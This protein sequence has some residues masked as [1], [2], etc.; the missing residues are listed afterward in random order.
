MKTTLRKYISITL[1]HAEKR[2]VSTHEVIQRLRKIFMC[3]AIVVATEKHKDEEGYHFHIALKNKDA[4]KHTATKRIRDIFQE[5][6]GM[7]CKVQFQKGI[8]N[9]LAYIT[10]ED[11]TP[12]V[13]GE[14]SLE[15]IL[16]MAEGARNHKRNEIV[17]AG[18]IIQKIMQC[19]DWYNVY[20]DPILRERLLK[21]YNN[22][23]KIHEDYQIIKNIKSTVGERLVEYLGN[24]KWPTEYSPEQIKEKYVLIDWVACQLCFRRPIKTKQLF[25][26]GEPSTQKTLII[27]YLAK[28]LRVYFVSARR[29]D[30]AGADD[31]YD[32][33]V[34]DEFNEPEEGDF[35]VTAATEGGTAYA[36][37]L[38]RVLDGQECRLDAKY[39]K[40]FT[41]KINVPIIM[42]A[43]RL[44][45][46]VKKSGPMQER[47]IRLRFKTNI[48]QLDEERV[49]ATLWGCIRRRTVRN[50][51]MQRGETINVDIN[52][53]YNEARAKEMV[54]KKGREARKN[55]RRKLITREN[56][57]IK[58]KE[59]ALKYR[60]TRYAYEQWEEHQMLEATI[61]EKKIGG[62]IVSFINYAIIP[63]E[64]KGVTKDSEEE[65]ESFNDTRRGANF[66]IRR[67]KSETESDYMTWPIRA[68]DFRGKT[69]MT[70]DL[71][72]MGEENE[73]NE[74]EEENQQEKWEE[75]GDWKL[76]LGPTARGKPGSPQW[77]D[78]D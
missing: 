57:E 67:R 54:E 18:I 36:N 31:Y 35:G 40:I 32:M 15:Q 27:N 4:S 48:E 17:P 46:A 39:G 11:K 3:T 66:I 26:Y 25:I 33:W 76:V 16:K 62:D 74:K 23:K 55:A 71:S 44:P 56:Q 47:M 37:T 69:I 65:V 24:K 20:E 6:Q 59:I 68:E 19:N 50:I 14:Y 43:N 34:F 58:I 30:F 21:A 13:W 72:L 1:S 41:K 10:K 60:D 7:Q 70:M 61:K 78:N 38:L 51:N 64:K 73:T 75:W 22:M 52:M 5:F 77:E 53:K 29:N 12:T 28:V 42:I 9:I 49:I 63:L 2:N 45:K 8:G